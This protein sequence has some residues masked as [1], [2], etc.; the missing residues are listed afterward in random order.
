MNRQTRIFAPI[1]NVNPDEYWY[2]NILGRVIKPITEKWNK[3]DW[4]WFS[5]YEHSLDINA[6]ENCVV[7]KIGGKFLGV[8]Y[9]TTSIRF[10]FSVDES[11]HLQFESDLETLIK[12][13]GYFITDFRD[14]DK[15]ETGSGRHIGGQLTAERQEKRAERVTRFYHQ[16]ALLTLDALEF[17]ANKQ[18][19]RFE[20]TTDAGMPYHNSCF[21]TPHHLFC[22]ITKIPLY[23]NV[24]VWHRDKHFSLKTE[25][26]WMAP[27]GHWGDISHS[28]STPDFEKP[29]PVNFA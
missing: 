29:M 26:N 3:L 24:K 14:W 9:R 5:R 27:T 21:T 10:R 25:T 18:L 7:N 6:D 1:D 15:S 22:N 8:N 2:E 28:D 4:F 17:D 16:T 23:A 19:Y 11:I 12:S 13:H 20:K